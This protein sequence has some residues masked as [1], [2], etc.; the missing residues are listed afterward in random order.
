MWERFTHRCAEQECRP[1]LVDHDLPAGGRAKSCSEVFQQVTRLSKMLGALETARERN[2]GVCFERTSFAAVVSLLT[3]L[4]MRRPYV[5]LSSECPGLGRPIQ[6]FVVLLNM[7][8][9]WCIL[10]GSKMLSFARSAWEASGKRAERHVID[11][12]LLISESSESSEVSLAP[13]DSQNDASEDK[14]TLYIIFTSGSTGRPKGVHGPHSATLNRLRWQWAKFPWEK[15]EVAC[16]RTPLTFVDHVAEVFGSLLAVPG[17]VLVCP[18]STSQSSALLTSVR[19]FAV[20]RLVLTPT[21]LRLLLLEAANLESP[22]RSLRMLTCSGELLTRSLVAQARAQLPEE[23]KLLNI[24]GSTEVA[25]DATCAELPDDDVEDETPL[26]PCGRAIDGVAVHL[27]TELEDSTESTESAPELL[28]LTEMTEDVCFGT[29]GEVYVTGSC[30]AGGYCDYSADNKV[31]QTESFPSIRGVRCFRSNDLARWQIS[32]KHQRT[33]YVLGRC[34]QMVKVRGQRVELSSVEAA[35]C[36]IELAESL[37]RA[38]RDVHDQVAGYGLRDPQRLQPI[39]AQAACFVDDSGSL[40]AAGVLS[41]GF[42]GS[43]SGSR[44]SPSTSLMAAVRQNMAHL[45]PSAAVPSRLIAVPSLP[46]LPSGKV[47]RSKLMSGAMTAQ[48]SSNHAQSTSHLEQLVREIWQSCLNSP[49]GP[50]AALDDDESFI[51]AGGD[52][53]GLMKMASRLRQLCTS[54]TSGA[55]FVGALP[56][57]AVPEFDDLVEA[58]STSFSALL[59]LCMI[60]QSSRKRR[61]L[62]SEGTDLSRVGRVA[63][64]VAGCASSPHLWDS[65]PCRPFASDSF[66]SCGTASEG[67][68][69]VV[70]ARGGCCAGPASALQGSQVELRSL[71]Q[72]DALLYWNTS[73]PFFIPLSPCY[74]EHWYEAH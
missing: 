55:G 47:D 22:W 63:S 25:G 15:G 21:L 9:V 29:V 37:I 39:F 24:Y 42:N 70:H 53:A 2:I 48:G 73:P 18:L 5:P 64:R 8:G 67:S 17:P 11:V 51:A 46:K 20:T 27:H 6:R 7:A 60:P 74:A 50:Q 52:S 13:R 49:S 58:A 59:Q 14:D 4:W 36:S 33:L 31:I 3:A 43:D 19:Q 16:A 68:A 44:G 54:G 72:G 61:R 32:R 12:E 1:A 57:L 10:C 65:L 41:P 35:L 38:T 45:L 56:V 40:V 71:W 34:G 26:V 30:L 28:N 69:W 62:S 66:G 23:C